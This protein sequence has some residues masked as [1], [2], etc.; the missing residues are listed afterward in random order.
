MYR[1]VAIKGSGL[2]NRLLSPM[3]ATA[4]TVQVCNI[5]P[6]EAFLP[7]GG[8]FPYRASIVIWI[9]RYLQFSCKSTQR[10]SRVGPMFCTG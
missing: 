2:L 8:A 3:K 1:D 10:L 5:D 7:V 9:F 6:I 4:Q